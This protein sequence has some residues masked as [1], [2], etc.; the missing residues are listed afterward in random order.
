VCA[1]FVHGIRVA[2]TRLKSRVYVL[3]CSETEDRMAERVTAQVMSVGEALRTG[4]D[5]FSVAASGTQ[6]VQSSRAKQRRTR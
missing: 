5:E 3:G 1:K 6:E 2:E 4:Y